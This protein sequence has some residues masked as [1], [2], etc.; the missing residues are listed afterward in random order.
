MPQSVVMMLIHLEGRNFLSTRLEGSSDVWARDYGQ[1]LKCR[2]MGRDGRGMEEE[3]QGN[4]QRRS[5]K[6]ERRRSDTGSHGA[7]GPLPSHTA[8]RSQY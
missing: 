3:E 5:R 7:R 4:V 2:G 6:E 1:R 8:A